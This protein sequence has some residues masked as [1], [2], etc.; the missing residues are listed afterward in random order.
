MKDIEDKKWSDVRESD[1]SNSLEVSVTMLRRQNELL[2]STFSLIFVMIYF[3][4][5]EEKCEGL[6]CWRISLEPTNY[7][8]LMSKCDIYL[9][10]YQEKK[11]SNGTEFNGIAETNNHTSYSEQKYRLYFYFYQFF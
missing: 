1:E 4:V 7:L 10:I 5:K 2:N 6:F 11:V 9:S 8:Y 3:D